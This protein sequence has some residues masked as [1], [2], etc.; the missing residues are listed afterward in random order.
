M[1]LILFLIFSV[2]ARWAG[3]TIV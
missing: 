3:E 1:G 2:L